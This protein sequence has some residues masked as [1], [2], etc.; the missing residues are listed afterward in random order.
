MKAQSIYTRND[1][2]K[3][4]GAWSNLNIKMTEI[5]AFNETEHFKNVNN[6]LNTNIYSYVKTFV[7]QSYYI[8]L[9]VVHFFQHLY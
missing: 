2:V 7:V 4:W 3:K 6:Y 9:N 8:Y 1:S 5:E